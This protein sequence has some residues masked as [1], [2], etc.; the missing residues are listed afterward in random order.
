MTINHPAR[1]APVASVIKYRLVGFSLAVLCAVSVPARGAVVFLDT[2]DGKSDGY[3]DINVN[4]A[5]RQAGG[6]TGSSYTKT[7]VG[8]GGGLTLGSNPSLGSDVLLLR[9]TG[10]A[11]DA[12]Y[13]AVDLDTDFGPSLA[14]NT[15][16]LSY[17]TR[18]QRG[19]VYSGYTGFAVGSPADTSGAGS[20]FAFRIGPTGSWKVY[21]QG[22]QVGSGSAGENTYY[23]NYSVRA[24]FYETTGMAQLW[25]AFE[26]TTNTVYLGSFTADFADDSRFVELRNHLDI[27]TDTG[28]VDAAFDDLKI[29]AS[30][31]YSSWSNRYALTEGPDGDDDSDGL[32]NLYEYGLG[33]D[34]TNENDRGT[35]PEFG[36]MQSGGTNWFRYVHP[37]L[38]DPFSGLSYSL[39]LN[40]NLVC[41]VWTNAGYAVLGTNGSG[42][43][44][45]FVTNV[46]SMEE[47][48]KFVRLNISMTRKLFVNHFGA[49]GDGV[50]DDTDAVVAAIDA[51]EEMG[52]G[53]TLEFAAGKTYNLEARANTPYQIDLQ[54]LTNVTVNGN[55][56]LLLN[57]PLRSTIR[58][59]HCEGVTVKNFC[60][61]QSSRSYTQ[62]TMTNIDPDAGTF[63]LTVDDGY[64]APPTGG[65]PQW[66]VVFDPAGWMRWDM[67]SHMRLISYED[68][69]SGHYLANVNSAYITDLND[70]QE[71]DTYLQPLA[72]INF[73][74]NV[75]ITL[76][77]NCLLE[78]VALYGGRS[79]MSSRVDLNTGRITVRGFKVMIPPYDPD[80][81]I[82]NWR[83]GVHCKDNRIGPIIE[84]CHFEYLLD[85]S[86]NMSQNTVMASEIISDTTFRMTKA[87]GPEIWTE[88]SSS[89]HVG[90]RIMVFYPPTGEYIGPVLVAS[91]DPD[92]RELITFD[93]PLTNVVAGTVTSGDTLSTHFYNLDMCNAGY[94]IRN[95][96]FMPQRRHAILARSID[97]TI[98]GNWIEGVGGNGIAMENEYGAA[99]FSGPFPQ[100]VIVSN[101]TITS[102]H[103]TP[104]VVQAK[105]GSN[106]TQLAQD[107][108]I[109]GN[110]ITASEAPAIELDNVRDVAVW[111]DNRFYTE[112]GSEMTDPLQVTDSEDIS[113]PAP[114]DGGFEDAFS[115]PDGNRY[116]YRPTGTPWTFSANAGYSENNTA[117][118]S[119]NPSAPE[120]SQVLFLQGLGSVSQSVALDAGTYTLSFYAAQ[121]NRDPQ[122][123]QLQILI[124]GNPVGTFQP[125][126]GGAY[127]YFETTFT[128]PDRCNGLLKL[129]GMVSPQD[130]TVLVDDIQLVFGSCQCAVEM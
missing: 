71:G 40:T 57:T 52:P 47:D 85:D 8:D 48:Q 37:Q 54:Y 89:M 83:D 35:S 116:E 49:V 5:T 30:L 45:N 87:E 32:A 76:S 129:Q 114:Q 51:L 111:S 13:T 97:G 82:S 101:N 12:E 92:A 109:T 28:V 10:P 39:E 98:S 1:K 56:A 72:Y 96:T 7:M 119:L 103:E 59:S 68:L 38:S 128:L 88:D 117:F 69:G 115:D 2:F 43:D 41:G 61:D 94:I 108:D 34:P 110:L 33:G 9:T 126:T 66:G 122:I 90:D 65:T 125:S 106:N 21:N 74:D 107:I 60:I 105:T 80:R 100:N 86:I 20:G 11:T 78:N 93:T 27:E 63:E 70:V 18:L 16:E 121:R 3:T 91:V 58:I 26:G 113:Y 22:T 118:T 42:G 95:N 4:L 64:P 44:L 79:A 6:A 19:I 36:V 25:V 50:T 15:W 46:I 81:L 112:D 17:R 99:Y 84:D 120:G 123:Q 124:G 62:G 104:L 31:V 53:A 55:G 67:R 73:D 29:E 127:E 102:T 23:N 77:S 75:H 14:G 130:T 24:A